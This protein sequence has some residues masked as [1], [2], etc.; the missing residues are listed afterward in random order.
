MGNKPVPGTTERFSRQKIL[1][2]LTKRH[3]TNYDADTGRQ[4]AEVVFVDVKASD[5]VNFSNIDYYDNIVVVSYLGRHIAYE[6]ET[7]RELWSLKTSHL[8]EV[9]AYPTYPKGYVLRVAETRTTAYYADLETGKKLEARSASLPRFTISNGGIRELDG[10]GMRMRTEFG[11]LI[12]G[13]PELLCSRDG[14]LS[15][16]SCITGETRKT[17]VPFA[18][19]E[20]CY[21]PS[22]GYLTIF[23]EGGDG[24]FSAFSSWRTYRVSDWVEVARS[25]AI[26][27]QRPASSS[28]LVTEVMVRTEMY[29]RMINQKRL[30]DWRREEGDCVVDVVTGEILLEQTDQFYTPVGVGEDR[31]LLVDSNGTIISLITLHG[32]KR[33]LRGVG[34]KTFRACEDVLI[35]NDE[36]VV[37]GESSW[38]FKNP[39][40]ICGEFRKREKTG[41]RERVGKLAREFFDGLLGRDLIGL[42]GR[43]V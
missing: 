5:D 12:P 25:R 42:V 17:S 33:D 27:L 22:P 39:R 9:R 43:Y 20:E 15:V 30:L 24:F 14:L 18:N 36:E 19:G 37:Q 6:T 38:K 10:Y 29:Y 4:L 23:G 26:A 31:L 41:E 13:I 7:L 3:L 8:A 1:T 21:F 35:L 34:F 16:M 40:Q 28:T 11:L 32:E 2:V